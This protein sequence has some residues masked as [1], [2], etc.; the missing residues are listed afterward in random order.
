MTTERSGMSLDEKIIRQRFEDY[1]QEC[2]GYIPCDDMGRHAHG[3]YKDLSIELAWQTYLHAKSEG[4]LSRDAAVSDEDV[5][6]ARIAFI[7]GRDGKGLMLPSFAC[8]KASLS[9]FA[10]RHAAV[11]D[12]YVLVPVEPTVEMINAGLCGCMDNDVTVSVY[13][14]M[15]AQRDGGAK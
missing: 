9:S 8:M 15:L 3:G 5:E 12:G 14:A 10:A 13:K 7:G 1:L 11:P 4:H 6:I 2:H